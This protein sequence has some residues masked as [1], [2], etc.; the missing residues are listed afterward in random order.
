[1]LVVSQAGCEVSA[2]G[3][4]EV[5]ET[6]QGE[7]HIAV[8]F[9]KGDHRYKAYLDGEEL[10]ACCVEAFAGDEGW[11]VVEIPRYAGAPPRVS[12]Y[13]FCCLDVHYEKRYGSVRI[14]RRE[15]NAGLE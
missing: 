3:Y 14:E 1:M 5:P 9:E 10:K 4:P 11:V 2:C 8:R 13:R 6:R 15:A 12:R 7:N